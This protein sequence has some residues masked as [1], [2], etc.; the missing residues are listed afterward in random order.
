M[1]DFERR[2]LRQTPSEDYLQP[3]RNSSRGLNDDLSSIK[4][5]MGTKKDRSPMGKNDY[6]D[7]RSRMES[8]K[9]V[10]KIADFIRGPHQSTPN[11]GGID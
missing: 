1:S 9:S 6:G 4:D 3:T 2:K 8:E 5:F 10:E 11:L 7:S